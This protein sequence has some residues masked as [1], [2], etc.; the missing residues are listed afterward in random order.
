M[1]FSKGCNSEFI[2]L[3]M[4]NNITNSLSNRLILPEGKA[5]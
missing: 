1:Y 3:N 4:D 5:V 2:S